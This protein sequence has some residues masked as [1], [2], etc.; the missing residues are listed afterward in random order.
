MH[1]Y[2]AFY[3]KDIFPLIDYDIYLLKISDGISN[4]LCPD[5]STIKNQSNSNS[6]TDNKIAEVVKAGIN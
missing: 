1:I 2:D 6:T 3:E 5:F 4:T